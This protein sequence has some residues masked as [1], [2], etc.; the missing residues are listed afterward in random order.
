MDANE[1]NEV[2]REDAPHPAPALAAGSSMARPVRRGKTGNKGSAKTYSYADIQ[3]LKDEW[4]QIGAGAVLGDT[5][6]AKRAIRIA[7]REMADTILDVT[8]DRSEY[9]QSLIR[10]G[11]HRSTA[12]E[13]VKIAFEM[14]AERHEIA[15][16]KIPAAQKHTSTQSGTMVSVTATVPAAP[17]GGEAKGRGKPAPIQPAKPLN[18]DAREPD[19]WVWD[20]DLQDYRDPQTLKSGFQRVRDHHVWDRREGTF[21]DE[22]T[23]PDGYKRI[24]DDWEWNSTMH[25]YQDPKGG[26]NPFGLSLIGVGNTG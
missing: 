11:F 16:R 1:N 10:G 6:Y 17:H 20:K 18:G 22:S 21:I 2:T 26:K 7:A 25:A 3:K 13:I 5:L 9:V 14:A 8:M 15:M 19:G 23:L 4:K 24:E 12:F